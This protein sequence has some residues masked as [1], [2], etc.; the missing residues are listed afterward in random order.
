MLNE[1]VKL[2]IKNHSLQESPLEACGLILFNSDY[3]AFPCRNSAENKV[4]SFVLCPEDYLKAS[5][6]GEIKAIYHSHPAADSDQY[7]SDIDEACSERHK[8]PYITYKLNTDSFAIY[9]P[10]GKVNPLI[11]RKY[12][13]GVDDCI[14]LIVDYYKRKLNISIKDLNHKHRFIDNKASHPD[15]NREHKTLQNYYLENNFVEVEDLKKH[16]VI[17]MKPPLI[18][19]ATHAMVYLGDGKVL[20]FPL[21][22]PSLIE[23]YCGSIK[24]RTCNIFRHKKSI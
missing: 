16:D 13:F 9:E 22:G 17:L 20:H 11:N 24:Q 2:Q 23:D 21:R 5:L 4:N 15:N 7:F 3:S 14:T 18:K 19:S 12:V 6:K 8:I 10:T 1:T